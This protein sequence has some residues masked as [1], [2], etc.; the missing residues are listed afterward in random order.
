M[1]T[2]L[3]GFVS[4][5][6]I[7]CDPQWPGLQVRTVEDR[8]AALGNPSFGTG[9]SARPCPGQA[10]PTAPIHHPI[11]DALDAT[12]CI[13]FMSMSVVW[14]GEPDDRPFLIVDITGDGSQA[15]IL[16]ALVAATWEILLPV[17]AA[18]QGVD[19]EKEM[20][21][22]LRRYAR[23]AAAL[24][25]S[26]PLPG[27]TTGLA[28]Q[29]TPGLSVQ[30]ILKDRQVERIAREAV[31]A[32]P[33]PTPRDRLQ[34]AKAALS[35]QGVDLPTREQPPPAQVAQGDAVSTLALYIL[36]SALGSGGT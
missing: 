23:S 6:P 11:A 33:G 20:L 10:P 1:K 22:C 28:F 4:C 24:W 13:H 27:Q 35:A 12:G 26:I 30:R 3:R 34:A 9:K 2:P 36:V 8:L 17:F 18:A 32:T 31:L 5:V 7:R 14:N 15:Q 29:G 21:G 25:F 19:S 16:R